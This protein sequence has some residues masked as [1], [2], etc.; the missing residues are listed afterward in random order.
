MLIKQLTRSSAEKVYVIA[1]NTA[2]VKLSVGQFIAWN[3]A[4]TSSLGNAITGLA[5]STVS[6]FAGVVAG[7]AVTYADIASNA[8]GLIQVYGVHGSVAYNVGAASI[9]C[10]GLWL[11]PVA[12]LYSGQT[13]QISGLQFSY[14]S[15][16]LIV[17]RGAVLMN[18]DVSATGW[19]NAFVRAL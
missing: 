16:S 7:G 9:S 11:I 2:G 13:N 6:L 5:T 3:W 12:A 17:N 18:N 8:Y 19:T 10:A 15:N 1:Q 14:A 4:A